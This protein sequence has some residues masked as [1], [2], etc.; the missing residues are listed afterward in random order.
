MFATV[1]SEGRV[2]AEWPRGKRDRRGHREG[3]EPE[4]DLHGHA[5]EW[6]PISS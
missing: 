5:H 6:I 3:Q 4:H 1:L 2:G